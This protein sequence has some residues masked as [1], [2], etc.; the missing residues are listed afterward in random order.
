MVRLLTALEAS[1][2]DDALKDAYNNLIDLGVE[3]EDLQDIKEARHILKN[4]KQKNI[5]DVIK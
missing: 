4:L 3:P 2:I 1:L 5:E